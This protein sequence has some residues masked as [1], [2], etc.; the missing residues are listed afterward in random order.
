VWRWSVG[1]AG[2][3]CEKHGGETIWKMDACK[4]G[5]R[6]FTKER[7]ETRF[8]TLT[9]LSALSHA[10]STGPA[11]AIAA[12]KMRADSIPRGESESR[13]G[14]GVFDGG[15]RLELRDLNRSQEEKHP[16]TLAR[17]SLPMPPFH[18]FF[19]FFLSLYDNSHS[20]LSFFFFLMGFF[21]LLPLSVPFFF[22]FSF[23]RPTNDLRS[24]P[25]TTKERKEP[26]KS[27]KNFT[28]KKEKL[29]PQVKPTLVTQ[30]G[31]LEESFWP[32]YWSRPG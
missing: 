2:R 18:F 28:Q 10:I 22:S 8:R 11:E 30:T 25:I 1:R 26:N 24:L 32:F 21:F 19:I 15:W 31:S 12:D 3:G 9:E 20:S 14:T 27:K 7:T 29:F 5:G 6:A 17:E 4:R 16:A 23:S 13:C